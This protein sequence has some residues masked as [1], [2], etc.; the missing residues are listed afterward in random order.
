MI[1]G[2]LIAAALILL[3]LCLRLSLRVVVGDSFALY[4]CVGLFKF[5]IYPKREKIL[6]LR[7]Y[8]IARFRRGR[9][10]SKKKRSGSK[11]EGKKKAP[12]KAA[13]TEDESEESLS[14]LINRLTRTISAFGGYFG[15]RLRIR[16]R[17]LV[18]VI[19]T[20]DPAMTAIVYGAALGAVQTIYGL[21]CEAGTISSSGGVF[22]V[23][24]D[25]TAEK[26]HIDADIT[27]SLTLRQLIMT[28]I[29]TLIAYLRDPADDNA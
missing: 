19:G 7:D 22:D 12:A 13:P 10:S 15:G 16:L 1:L 17:R 11:P 8:D 18:I 26:S 25:F 21:L 23:I 3:L 29:H 6:R 2:F 5:R 20:S 14:D 28:A 24:P 4:A 27:L 9:L